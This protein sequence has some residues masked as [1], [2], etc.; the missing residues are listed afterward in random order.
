MPDVLVN[1]FLNYLFL[2]KRYSSHTKMAY[3]NDLKQLNAYLN[4]NKACLLHELSANTLRDYLSHL[5]SL[6]T[7][8]RTVKRKLSCFKSFFKY[9]QKKEIVKI[10]P[11]TNIKGPKTQKRLPVFI[12]EPQ[13]QHLINN[14]GPESNFEA[15]R[16]YLIFELLYQTGIR[17][18]ELLNLQETDI[19]LFNLQIKVLGKR[20]KERIIPISLQLKRNLE[21][22]LAVKS[23][24]NLTNT[25]L[26]V[27]KKNKTL[28][29]TFL[30]KLI[31]E[32][33]SVISNLPKKSPHVLRHTF[34]THLLNNG[35]DINAV[36]ELLGH[37]NLQATQIYTHNS[38]DKLKK[39]YARAHP[40]SGE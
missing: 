38:I 19:D 2:Q 18:A 3:S 35:A 24:E 21:Y 33:L 4:H 8:A 25:L 5:V 16:N 40:R 39:T 17:R 36:K 11:A 32:M 13:M 15:C 26:L 7:S 20:N 1:D 31:S 14:T 34:A 30:S 37:A 10:N 23:K 22:Y 27:N 6:G 28:S 29:T 9:L 12:N